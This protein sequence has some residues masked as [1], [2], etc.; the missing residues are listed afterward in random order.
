[1]QAVDF[2]EDQWAKNKKRNI[3]AKG[4]EVLSLLAL[5]VLTYADV[6]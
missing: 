4:D 1:M 5:R 3:K 6:C 2:G